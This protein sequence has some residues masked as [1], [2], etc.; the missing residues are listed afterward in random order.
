MKFGEELISEHKWKVF[1]H[2]KHP[3]ND[4]N[5]SIISKMVPIL[6][7]ER[8]MRFRFLPFQSHP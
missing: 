3:E 5:L 7:M 4:W 1:N 6:P 2:N 8:C